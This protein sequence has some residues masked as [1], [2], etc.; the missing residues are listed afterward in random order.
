MLRLPILWLFEDRLAAWSTKAVPLADISIPCIL[1]T[2]ATKLNLYQWSSMSRGKKI[3]Q[4]TWTNNC[5]KWRYILSHKNS[6][7]W[8]RTAMLPAHCSHLFNNGIQFW[9]ACWQK[10]EVTESSGSFAFSICLLEWKYSKRTP[11]LIKSV[12]SISSKNK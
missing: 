2:R 4:K 1:W 6:I 9:A 3:T 8:T 10:A 7:I 11:G 5:A 12:T